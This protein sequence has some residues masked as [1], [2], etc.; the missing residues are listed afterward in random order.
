MAATQ[1]KM[2]RTAPI[3]VSLAAAAVF[4][5]SVVLAAGN[6]GNWAFPTFLAVIAIVGSALMVRVQRAQSRER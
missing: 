3:T 2:R 4:G 6:G 1:A 5:F